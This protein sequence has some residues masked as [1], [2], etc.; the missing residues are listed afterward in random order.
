VDLSGA[1]VAVVDLPQ[2]NGEVVRELAEKAKAACPQLLLALFGREEGRVPFVVVCQGVPGKNAGQIAKTL[3]PHLGG[4]GG[5]RPDVAQG[6]G[7][8]PEGVSAALQ[9]V[10]G[11]FG[12]G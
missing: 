5:G 3:G 1:K 12:L 11:A 8:K 4:G 9:T 2:A 7:Q 6:Q 10:R